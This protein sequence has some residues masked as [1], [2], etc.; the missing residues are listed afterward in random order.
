MR[1]KM[2]VLSA[3]LGAVV[4][5]VSALSMRDHVRLVEIVS[6][7]FGGFGSGAGVAALA[8]GRRRER[9]RA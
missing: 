9:V 8:A 6:L 7:F 3:V 5:L 2:A 1:D 4:T